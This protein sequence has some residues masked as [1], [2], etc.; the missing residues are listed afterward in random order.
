MHRLDLRRRGT[1]SLVQD[2]VG[3]RLRLWPSLCHITFVGRK[4]D[5]GYRATD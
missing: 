2:K 3:N 5:G 4:L 1:V